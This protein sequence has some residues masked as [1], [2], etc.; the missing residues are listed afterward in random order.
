[1]YSRNLNGQILTMA[2][3][4]WTWHD[5]FVLQ[6]LETGSLWWT[7]VGIEGSDIMLCIS[8]PLQNERTAKLES[9][10]GYWH[11]WVTQHPETKYL[12]TK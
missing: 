1:V 9:F 11:G 4:G 6:D 12:K 3:S 8:G 7:G 10:R 2:A 5:K